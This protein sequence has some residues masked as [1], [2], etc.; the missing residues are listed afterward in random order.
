[1]IFPAEWAPQRALWTAW[2]SDADLWRDDLTPARLEVARMAKALAPHV[3][4]HIVC[5]HDEA[6]ACARDSLG[7]AAS[8]H[9]I[10]FG[11]I[12]LRDTAPLFRTASDAL[13]FTFNG[14]G[15]KYNLP[16]DNSLAEGIA[17]AAG[18]PLT[19][20]PMVLEGGAIDGDGTG[21]CVT[22]EQCLL[23]PNRNPAMTRADIEATLAETLGFTRILWL[24]DG[25]LNDHT[26]GH[27]DNLAR[28]VA[29]NT[30]ALP[31]ATADDPNADVIADARARAHD[32]GVTV[33][34]IPSVGQLEVDGEAL[35]A[36][37]MNFVIANRAVVVPTY[38]A[39]NDQA[40]V[41]A[42]AALF[43]NHSVTG[44][45]ANHILTGGGSFHC[46]TQQVPA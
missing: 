42:I 12:W 32:F 8:V 23:N 34:D 35:P 43:P 3:A 22:T 45:R 40:A 5:A 27:V 39:P 6:L 14:W 31:V 41:A 10:P 44:H 16:F 26:D 36:S 1:M 11:D 4:L 19:R 17:L 30:L 46:I 28:F 25:L 9:K 15:G 33:V 24:G 20:H 18:V 38:G 2:P 21:L 7:G 29:P 37:Y 13:A